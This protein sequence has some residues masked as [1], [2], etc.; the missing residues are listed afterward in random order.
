MVKI[1]LP[2][3][4][5]IANA[6][7]AAN[8]SRAYLRELIGNG[9]VVSVKVGAKHLV[10]LNSLAAYLNGGTEKESTADNH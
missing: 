5:S 9:T 10:N 2:R 6:A 8:I 3:M 7:K 1:E 4:D